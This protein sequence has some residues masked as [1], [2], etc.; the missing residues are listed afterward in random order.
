MGIVTLLIA[1]ITEAY[2]NHYKA[3]VTRN[4]KKHSALRPSGSV[5]IIKDPEEVTTN[6]VEKL[7]YEVCQI[8]DAPVMRANPVD[9][10]LAE[11][12]ANP[13]ACRQTLLDIRS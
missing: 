5:P 4:G 10:W 6:Q 3:F 11:R 12:M 2:S 13:F 8:C 7:P 9:S 1:V